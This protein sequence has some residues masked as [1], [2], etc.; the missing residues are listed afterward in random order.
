MG[1]V[2]DYLILALFLIK[3]M[4]GMM[5]GFPVSKEGFYHIDIKSNP[6]GSE[7]Q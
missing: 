1:F 5:V 7:A 6:N 4:N 2:F 3:T